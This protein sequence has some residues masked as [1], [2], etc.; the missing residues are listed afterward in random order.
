[1][2]KYFFLLLPVLFLGAG[3]VWAADGAGG[4][5]AGKSLMESLGLPNATVWDILDNFVTALLSLLG[6]V[7]IIAFVISGFKYLQSAGE[8]AEAKDAKNAMKYSI[9]G[10]IVALM[11]LVILQAVT[12]MLNAAGPF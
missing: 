10:V 8:E 7:S 4:W 5:A 1:M 9:Y 2:K 6:L 3:Q 11:G 12:V